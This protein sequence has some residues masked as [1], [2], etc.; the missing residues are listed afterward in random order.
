LPSQFIRPQS[1]NALWLVDES[2]AAL[3]DRAAQSRGA[4]R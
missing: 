4:A 2:A 1:G 3:L